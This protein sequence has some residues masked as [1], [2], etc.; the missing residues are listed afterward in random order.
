MAQI[1]IAKNYQTARGRRRLPENH[2]CQLFCHFHN[3]KTT[4]ISKFSCFGTCFILQQGVILIVTKYLCDHGTPYHH[5]PEYIESHSKTELHI[6]QMQCS[7]SHANNARITYC[8]LVE[9][10]WLELN[11]LGLAWLGAWSRL[12]I[13][14]GSVSDWIVATVFHCA[15]LLTCHN[16]WCFALQLFECLI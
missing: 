7:E 16:R 9:L 1:S 12:R 3:R 2:N 11:R 5:I 13:V 14:D 6:C 4:K 10:I 8:D 15:L